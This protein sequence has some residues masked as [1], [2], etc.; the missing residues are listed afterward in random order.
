MLPELRDWHA[1]A[2]RFTEA[3]E[4]AKIRCDPPVSESA[5]ARLL[6]VMLGSDEVRRM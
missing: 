6:A 1:A 3:H 4:L 5:P 2:R